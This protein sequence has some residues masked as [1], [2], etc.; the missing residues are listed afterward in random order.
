MSAI[1]EAFTQRGAMKKL[2]TQFLRKK[3]FD[4]RNL[5]IL[6]VGTKLRNEENRK[7]HNKQR[8]SKYKNTKV[9]LK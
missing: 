1:P 4:R 3:K 7:E 6:S 2:P 9:F 8:N 5:F